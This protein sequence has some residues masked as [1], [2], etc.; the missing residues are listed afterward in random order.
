MPVM[1]GIEATKQIKMMQT[2]T[3]PGADV[4]IIACT[5]DISSQATQDF[6][7]SGVSHVLFK[8]VDKAKLAQALAAVQAHT[9]VEQ[10]LTLV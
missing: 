5:A 2:K 6:Y 7:D 9:K 8:P 10:P 4:P 3:S 1:T